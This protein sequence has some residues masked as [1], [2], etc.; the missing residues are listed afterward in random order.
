MRLSAMPRRPMRSKS[1]SKPNAFCSPCPGEGIGTE[2][3]RGRKGRVAVANERSS[4]GD[5]MMTQSNTQVGSVVAVRGAVVDVAFAAAPL[6]RLEEA[7]IVEWDRPEPLIVEV[8]AHLDEHTRARE[9]RCRRRPGSARRRRV[10]DR[11]H[12]VAVPVGDAS[13]AGCST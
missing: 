13:S 8:Q 4:F 12:R 9:W 2:Y 6:P 1:S 5:L 7:L 10:R 11:R 3:G